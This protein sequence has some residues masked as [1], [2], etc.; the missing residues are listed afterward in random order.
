MS[1]KIAIQSKGKLKEGSLKFLNAIGFNFKPNGD[2]LISS[3]K[4]GKG[5]ILLVRD[6]DIPSYVEKGIANY[7]IVGENVLY[8]NNFNVSVKKK[9]GFAKCNLMIAIP[10]DSNIKSLSDLNGKKF[11][12]CYPNLLKQY[13]KDNKIEASIITLTGSVEIAPALGLSDVICDLV[14]TGGTLKANGLKIFVEVMQSEA[15]LIETI[16]KPSLKFNIFKNENIKY[17]P[18]IG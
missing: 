8:E 2:K 7:G 18:A 1:P 9:L 10:E 6:D 16:S 13:L 11:A 3:C 5:E 17:Y 14:Q 15:V 4:Q 12:T